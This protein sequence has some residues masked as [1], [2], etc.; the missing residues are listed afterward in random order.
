MTVFAEIGR[1]DMTDI[2]A[3][4][5]AAVV[6]PGAAG[7]NGSVIEIGRYPAIGRMAVFARIAA[8]YMSRVLADRNRAVVTARAGSD[9]IEVINTNDR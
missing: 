1:N 5:R 7:C 8:G 9:H 6:T 3:S 2:L 4:R